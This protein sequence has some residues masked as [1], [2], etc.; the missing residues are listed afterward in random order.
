MTITSDLLL[1]Q[2]TWRYAV[3]KFDP[4]RKID[5]DTWQALMEALVLS[6]SSYGLQPWRFIV[7][8][9]P[10]IKAQL[11]VI[12]WKQNQPQ[13][14]S[15][16]VVLAAAEKLDAAYI[17]DQ[18]QQIAAARGVAPESLAGYRKMLISAVD[19][20]ESTLEWS[21]R[22]V[23]LALG[24]LMN[25]AAM[26]GIDSCPM[27]G[28]DPVAYDNLLGMSNSGY[29]SVVGCALGYRDPSDPYA[30]LKKVR[31]PVGQVVHEI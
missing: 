29:R 12:S 17:D 30:S 28:I 3:K 19:T 24:Q 14:C 27:E 5:P 21:S 8:T 7:I 13:D 31:F 15:H 25:A 23:Y 20:L 6:P 10:A 2:L 1:K 22:Q 18:I 16:M 4:T 11:P 26:L 9:N